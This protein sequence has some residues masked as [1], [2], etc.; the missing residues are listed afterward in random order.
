MMG[1]FTLL[2]TLTLW[3]GEFTLSA[4]EPSYCTVTRSSHPGNEEDTEIYFM[5]CPEADHTILMFLDVVLGRGGQLNG[6]PTLLHYRLQTTVYNSSARTYH[7]FLVTAYFKNGQRWA[8]FPPLSAISCLLD[9][10]HFRPHKRTS[11]ISYRHG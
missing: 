9:G 11:S 6:G 5:H 1:D 4:T 10:S 7:T 2:S 8:N 3:T